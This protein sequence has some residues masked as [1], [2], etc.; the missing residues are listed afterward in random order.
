MA[1]ISC[2][3]PKTLKSLL[4]GKLTGPES[5]QLEEHLLGCDQCLAIARTIPAS[6]ELTAAIQARRDFSSDEDVLAK[7]VERAKQLRFQAETMETAETLI[8]EST[9]QAEGA[10]DPLADRPSLEEEI[11]FLKK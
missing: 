7:A 1:V 6:D 4:S 5:V 8:A 3:P 10:A 9:S 11:D 2:P